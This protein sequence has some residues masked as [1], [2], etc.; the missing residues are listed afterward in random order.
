MEAPHAPD[1]R[2]Q[3]LFGPDWQTG[4]EPT[5]KAA[6]PKYWLHLLLFVLTVITTTLAGL[7]WMSPA[8]ASRLAEGTL[9]WQ[10]FGQGFWFSLPFLGILTVHEFGHYFT[11]RAYKAQVTLPYY[12]PMWLGWL[13]SFS[14]GTMGAFIRIGSPFKARYQLFDVGAAGPL[15]GYVAAVGVLVW[16]YLTLPP[17]DF[18]FTIHPE[19]LPLGP[20]YAKYVYQNLGAGNLKLGNNLTMQL[21]SHLADPARLPN[22][23]ELMHYPLLFAGFMA[24]FFTALNLFPIGQLDGGHILYGLVGPVWHGRISPLLFLCLVM[25]SGMGVP[26]PMLGNG[27]PAF[28]DNLQWNAV[29]LLFLYITFSRT[30]AGWRNIL[31]LALAVFGLQYGLGMYMPQ[32]QGY[33]GWLVFCLVLGRFLGI[34]HPPTLQDEPLSPGRKLVGIVALVVFILCF[35]PQPFVFQ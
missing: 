28:A 32:L 18:I 6:K 21:L 15:A 13:S 27:D 35:S 17:A 14:I 24:L 9:T 30:V 25:Y 7:E 11:A 20:D 2:P 3:D 31:M 16:G 23:Y 33:N 19:Y 4:Q 1:T 5:P 22:A 34:Y 8:N 10:I 29:Y 12:I 26:Q